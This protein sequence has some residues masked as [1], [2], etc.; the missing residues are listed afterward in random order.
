MINTNTNTN[1]NDN[2]NDNKLTWCEQVVGAVPADIWRW[3]CREICYEPELF[4]STYVDIGRQQVAD[5]W[6]LYTIT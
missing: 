2:D 1:T 5:V 3:I 6:R 4:A